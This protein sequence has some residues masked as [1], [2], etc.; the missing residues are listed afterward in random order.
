MAAA[1]CTVT[2][3]TCDTSNFECVLSCTGDGDCTDAAQPRCDTARSLCVECL[4]TTDCTAPDT[5]D[6]M[7]CVNAGGAGGAAGGGP[8]A[9]AGGQAGAP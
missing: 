6:N 4:D 9:G 7:E 5:C 2:G 8:V 1:D 3:E